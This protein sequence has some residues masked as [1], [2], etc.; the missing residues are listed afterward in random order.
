MI[1]PMMAS[2][3][4]RSGTNSCLLSR[5]ASTAPIV[6]TEASPA[7]TRGANIACVQR[8]GSP[9]ARRAGLPGGS[10][11]SMAQ[12]DVRVMVTSEPIAAR[13]FMGVPFSYL[14]PVPQRRPP[15]DARTL[16]F[17]VP[18]FLHPSWGPS[19]AVTAWPDQNH[20]RHGA[21]PLSRSGK[22]STEAVLRIRRA[23]GSYPPAD[24]GSCIQQA[25]RHGLL[26][27]VT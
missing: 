1:P 25:A 16:S 26:A 22:E 15:R 9:T 12:P 24:R 4:H 7:S 8:T 14:P 5:I 23:V 18:A 17:R 13:I 21:G 6:V 2:S 19:V 20:S 3:L 11:T 27:V 10:T